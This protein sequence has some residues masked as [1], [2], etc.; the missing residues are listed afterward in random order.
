MNTLLD[1]ELTRA[2]SRDPQHAER[3]RGFAAEFSASLARI[4][5]PTRRSR[6][7]LPK[8][9]TIGSPAYT[10]STLEVRPDELLHQPVFQRMETD[11]GEAA[12]DGQQFAA[13]P[14]APRQLAQ[15]VVDVH[16]QRLE[17]ARGRMLAALA[18]AHRA[19]NQR[20]ELPRWSLSVPP[21]AVHDD[22]GD[23]SRKAFFS[24]RTDHV[25]NLVGRGSGEPLRRACAMRRVH[26]HVERTVLLEAETAAGLVE[27]G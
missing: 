14:P 26:A 15:F 22:A 21:R 5:L 24:Q 17:G 11:H 4:L 2:P 8:L 6:G 12:A 25:A 1:Q 3:V 16:A 10:G 7:A 19:R 9:G 27:L 18:R 13:P 20:G 23:A